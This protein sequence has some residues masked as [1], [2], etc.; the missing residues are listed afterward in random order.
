MVN[1]LTL[2]PA[3]EANLPGGRGS[4]NSQIT[5]FGC[6][7]LKQLYIRIQ[8]CLQFHQTLQMGIDMIC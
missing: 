8:I 7:D 6:T 2:I 4:V 3:A 5:A 1:I